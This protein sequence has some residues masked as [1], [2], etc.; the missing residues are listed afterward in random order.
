MK[1][2]AV[3]VMFA[4]GNIA[5]AQE[6]VLLGEEQNIGT[7]KRFDY[8]N[9]RIGFAAGNVSGIGISFEKNVTRNLS[10]MFV[11]G[12][13]AQKSN[14]DFNTGLT[15]RH[16]FSRLGN[17][18]NVYMLLGGSYFYDRKYNGIYD[19]TAGT[20]SIDKKRKYVKIGGGLG[21]GV[22][23]L[24]GR[25]GVDVNFIGVGASFQKKQGAPYQLGDKPI[26]GPQINLSYNF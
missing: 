7:E 3:L 8:L 10:A 9:N 4:L 26:R 16:T 18:V 14:S 24:D 6:E 17:R 25:L 23:F 1:T 5:F 21:V 19:E 13:V 22:L 15:L 20:Y 2:I 12:G 11:I